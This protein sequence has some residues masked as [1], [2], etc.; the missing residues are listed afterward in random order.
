MSRS[1][2][3]QQLHSRG[4]K[5][6]RKTA[7]LFHA[8]HPD[9]AQRFK[10]FLTES[11]LIDLVCYS[12][13]SEPL[14]RCCS[15]GEV[16]FLWY[17]FYW[18][19]SFN[20]STKL[21]KN[22]YPKVWNSFT[23]SH[24]F[25][26][27]QWAAQASHLDNSRYFCWQALWSYERKTWNAINMQICQ[28]QGGALGYICNLLIWLGIHALTWVELQSWQGPNTSAY[29]FVSPVALYQISS[30]WLFSSVKVPHLQHFKM[31]ANRITPNMTV[32]CCSDYA[33]YKYPSNQCAATAMRIW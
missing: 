27:V 2:T 4:R 18:H 12:W 17:I 30:Q 29:N 15:M 23:G 25:L 6:R 9:Q 5:K 3:D 21:M 8:R 16:L 24:A 28:L 20:T 13:V 1:A 14:L 22:S 7:G 32:Y 11:V 10:C 26:L 19:Y 33:L 31:N